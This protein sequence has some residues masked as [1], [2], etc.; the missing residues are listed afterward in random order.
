MPAL[1][2]IDP[3]LDTR[4]WR[5][6]R[7]RRGEDLR[8]VFGWLE[9]AE[10]ALWWDPATIARALGVPRRRVQGAV[11]ALVTELAVERMVRPSGR[12]YRAICW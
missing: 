4:T 11:E 2:R 6:R 1:P 10:P 8:T 7:G 3:K 5:D 12:R 9:R